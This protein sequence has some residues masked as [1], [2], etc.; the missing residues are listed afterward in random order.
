MRAEKAKAI[1]ERYEQRQKAVF[2]RREQLFS[3]QMQDKKDRLLQQS[4]RFKEVSVPSYDYH[5][6]DKK[7]QA[8]E[9]RVKIQEEQ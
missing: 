2:E 3:A 4:K 6:D 7:R 5:V 9:R 1:A 8:D